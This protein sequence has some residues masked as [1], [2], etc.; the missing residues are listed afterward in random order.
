MSFDGR[1]G[2][3]E[4]ALGGSMIMLSDEYPETGVIGL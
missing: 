3:C 4:L 1:I 2:D